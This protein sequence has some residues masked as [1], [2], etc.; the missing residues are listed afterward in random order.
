MIEITGN[1]ASPIGYT[2]DG[3]HSGIKK[4]NLDLGWIVSEIPASVAY[5]QTTNKVKAAPLILNNETIQANGKVQAIIVNSGI[6]NAFTGS[7]GMEDAVSMQ[8]LT[9]NALNINQNLVTVASTGVIGK[10]LPMDIIDNGIRRLNKNGNAHHF[11]K[12]ILTTDLTTKT[13]VI[14]ETI[15]QQKITMAGV[16]KGSGMIHPNMATMLAF[17]TCDANISTETLQLALQTNVNKTFN[18]ITIDGDTSTND[19]VLVLS[20]GLAR[21]QEILPNTEEYIT[22]CNMLEHVMRNL[23]M[24][25]AKDGEGAT[26]LIEVKVMGMPTETSARMIAKTVVGSS[27]VK[28]AIFGEDPNWGRILAS[29]GYT[30]TNFDVTNID[31]AI[32]DILVMT[33]STPEAFDKQQMQHLLKKD[34]IKISINMHQGNQNGTAWGCDLTYDYVKINALYT[35]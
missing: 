14:T 27:L 23:A 3:I 20:N 4:K 1:I 26:K 9:A 28:S 6:A 16:A 33:H 12:A 8:Q 18:Q 22:F 5:V 10:H 30:K 15:Y 11:A 29:I 13:C 31:I 7:Q 25:I 35:T 19:L 17:I 32:E 21:N 24:K 2:A 34:H